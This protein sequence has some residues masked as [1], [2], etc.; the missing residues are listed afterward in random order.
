LKSKGLTSALYKAGSYLLENGVYSECRGNSAG[1]RVLQ[2]V[3]PIC[4]EIEN[5]RLRHVFLAERKWNGLLP[6]VE[7]LWIALGWN[8]L[9]DLPGRYVKALY[10]YS[11]D[12]ETWRAGYGPRIRNFTPNSIQYNVGDGTNPFEGQGTDQLKYVIESFKKDINT[13]QADISIHDPAKDCFVNGELIVTKDTP[14]TRSLHFQKNPK[15][16]CLDLIV[17]MRSNDI[18]FGFSA[19]NVFNF[20][21]MQEYVAKMVGLPLGKYFH[22][23]DNFHLYEK[24]I[25]KLKRILS[26]SAEYIADTE[27]DLERLMSSNLDLEKKL[28]LT[29][30]DNYI[31]LIRTVETATYKS[32]LKSAER[33]MSKL[34]K[35]P[36]L[37]NDW[38]V[39]IA[40]HNL[41]K[42]NLRKEVKEGLYSFKNDYIKKIYGEYI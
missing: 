1:N 33:A 13:R 2:L 32:D 18:L 31:R 21:L 29:Q 35:G 6:Y 5:P 3:E 36:E 12:G 16:G 9:D 26:Y 41:K 25:P 28:T 20:T 30:F 14:C 34:R 39:V 10:N 27:I 17:R 24:F 19:V 42:N 8:N 15:T 38:A 37:F 23:A 4:I 7:S 40:K 22:I 11:D